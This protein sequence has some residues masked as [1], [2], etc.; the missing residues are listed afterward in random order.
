MFNTEFNSIHTFHDDNFIV[1]KTRSA[2]IELIEVVETLVQSWKKSGDPSLAEKLLVKV[3]QFDSAV[4]EFYSRLYFMKNG[5]RPVLVNYWDGLRKLEIPY[6][7]T[8]AI[9]S[10]RALRNRYC[11]TYDFSHITSYTFLT[12]SDLD[13]FYGDIYNILFSIERLTGRK[14]I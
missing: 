11:H 6:F 8:Q 14:L 2:G 4:E 3:V 13:H 7:D 12:P 5:E 1:E 10:I 9:M